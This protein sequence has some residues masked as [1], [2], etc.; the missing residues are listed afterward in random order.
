M[1]GFACEN[2]GFDA[3]TG[4]VVYHMEDICVNVPG[5]GNG[6]YSATYTSDPPE[7]YNGMLVYVMGG[8]TSMGGR[9]FMAAYNAS[10]VI[11]A[12]AKGFDA[13]CASQSSETY[14]VGQ[15]EGS[16]TP[17]V[18]G[19]GP[20]WQV[21]LQPPSTGSANWDSQLCGNG[22]NGYVFDYPAFKSQGTM[23][24][25]CQN[26][27][28][29]VTSLGGG[30]WGFPKAVTSG[31]ST[32]W[33]QYAIDNQT[34]MMYFGTG[35]AGPFEYY[36]QAVRPGLDLY[37]SSEMAVNLNTGKVAWWFQMVPHGLSDWDNSWATILGKTNGT[38][39]V[40]KS[41]KDGI[42]FS[43]NAATGAPNWVF[44]NPAIAW[45][46]GL[47]PGDPTNATQMA[48]GWPNAPNSSWIQSPALAGSL[49][50]DLAY[51]GNTIFGAWFNSSPNVESV[52]P[53]TQYANTLRTLPWPDN[54]TVTAVNAN[55]GKP[56]WSHF[57]NGFVFR[58]GMTVSNGMLI[59]PGGDGNI[60]FLNAQNGDT[61]YS[62]HIGA[63]LFV[64]PTLGQNANGQEV[65]LQIIGGGRWLAVG[66]VGGG[67]TVPGA[68]VAFT[69]GAAGTSSTGP[70][71]TS[72]TA[73]AVASNLP[74]NYISYGAVAFAIII[75]VA[76]VIISNRSRNKG[77]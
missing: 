27:P 76:N 38:A 5:D 60:Y 13:A 46:P 68:L 48:Y 77:R 74:L 66:Q 63:P 43:M 20:M 11:A 24:I 73:I 3:T 71:T 44:A 51:D 42:L 35:E 26:I 64:D 14:T 58:G 40:F 8:Y 56:E 7:Y 61:I 18:P 1:T 57:F 25:A 41:T 53:Q 19:Q 39:S 50:S 10:A 59:M 23:A 54:V 15:V 65:M 72:T 12:G 52:N 67:L 37:S 34:G 21:F 9:A 45:A 31:V 36:N 32:S 29:S 16:C 70:A 22:V 4:D 30:D 17:Q 55:T 33:G 2:W 75:T 62:L 6:A 69:L 28:S 49:E 47:T